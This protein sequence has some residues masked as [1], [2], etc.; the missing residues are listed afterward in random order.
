M[1][2]KYLLSANAECLLR[3]LCCFSTRKSPCTGRA[4]TCSWWSYH[5]TLW[6]QADPRRQSNSAVTRQL[7]SQLAFTT[8][9]QYAY[10]VLAPTLGMEE[11]EAGRYMSCPQGSQGIR[12]L[13]TQ[14]NERE[15]LIGGRRV[16][17]EMAQSL[18]SLLH[19]H[20]DLRLGSQHACGTV[21]LLSQHWG[22]GGRRTRKFSA[23]FGCI[24]NVKLF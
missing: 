24:E 9:L 22:G 15:H 12:P 3:T 7:R 21:H 20:R 23:I 18:R 2:Q 16:L 17:K 13:R 19:R 8:P 6:G 5:P 11:R 4:Q 1:L 10:C 14:W